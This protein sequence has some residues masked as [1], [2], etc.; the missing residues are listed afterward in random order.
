MSERDY[1]V[2]Q[3]D[4]V[5]SVNGIDDTIVRADHGHPEINPVVSYILLSSYSKGIPL[6]AIIHPVD[7]NDQFSTYFFLIGD[8]KKLKNICILI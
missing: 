7:S 5:H 4:T 8:I 2:S 3:N 1:Y 6:K